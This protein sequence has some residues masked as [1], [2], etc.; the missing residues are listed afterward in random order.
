MS[1]VLAARDVVG[2][3]NGVPWNTNLNVDLSGSTVT[4][5]GQGNVAIDVARILLSNVDKLKVRNNLIYPQLI[6]NYYYYFSV[7]RHNRT[8]AR[9]FSTLKSEGSIP[10][11]QKR[12]SSSC[13][14]N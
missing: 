8:C 7:Y 14:Y 2:W 4:I 11:R 9:C 12:A 1:N 6:L 5:F 3:Y 10:D 13:L